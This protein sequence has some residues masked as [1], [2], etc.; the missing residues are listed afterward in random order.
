LDS[1][2]NCRTC[3]TGSLLVPFGSINFTT[4]ILPADKPSCN[5]R[6]TCSRMSCAPPVVRSL[7]TSKMV[8]PLVLARRKSSCYSYFTC[9]GTILPSRFNQKDG[10]TCPPCSRISTLCSLEFVVYS[11]TA[12]EWSARTREIVLRLRMM[13]RRV[14]RAILLG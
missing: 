11:R 9:F 3:S 8:A 14:D 1:F 4:A 5:A 10:H 12:R 13:A 6:S 7:V 2:G